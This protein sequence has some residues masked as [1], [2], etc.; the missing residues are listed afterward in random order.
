MLDEEVACSLV[1][2]FCVEE[3]VLG[4]LSRLAA[5]LSLLLWATERLC[6]S[7]LSGKSATKFLKSAEMWNFAVRFGYRSVSIKS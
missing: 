6:Q 3:L 2:S 1:S 5:G 7:S 4:F